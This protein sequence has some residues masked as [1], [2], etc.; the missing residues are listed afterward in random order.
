[1]QSTRNHYPPTISP[2]RGRAPAHFSVDP[3][4]LP[5]RPYRS[6]P[7]PHARHREHGGVD[8]FLV[9]LR[10]LEP[11]LLT[12]RPVVVGLGHLDLDPGGRRA[13][14]ARCR[15][16]CA[17]A[18]GWAPWPCGREPRPEPS[19]RAGTDPS[20]LGQ[21]HRIAIAGLD[22]RSFAEPGETTGESTSGHQATAPYRRAGHLW[23]RSERTSSSRVNGGRE[24]RRDCFPAGLKTRAP[25]ARRGS[26]TIHDG[27]ANRHGARALSAAAPGCDPGRLGARGGR[28]AGRA[29]C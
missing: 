4:C 10:P 7:L 29:R 22:V 15:A 19:S 2:Q 6:H 23:R 20:P 26:F 25:A 14:C 12:R 8:R 13:D 21:A 16:W 5:P 11:H 1:M 18:R 27:W 24:T 28:G 17:S 3:L 9:S